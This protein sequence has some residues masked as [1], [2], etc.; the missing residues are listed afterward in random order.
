MIIR[1]AEIA[2]PGCNGFTP[3]DIEIHQGKIRRIAKNLKGAPVLD[4]GGLQLFPGAIDPHVH[5]NEPGY[6][7]RED[8]YHGS[9]A[10]ASGGVSTVIDMPCTSVPPVTNKKN[11]EAKLALIEKRSIIDFAFFG[12]VS[13][14]CFFGDWQNDMKELAPDVMGFKC[15]FLS[16]MDSF[17]PLS[18]LQFKQVLMAATA[19]G[20]PLL[21]HAEDPQLVGKYTRR[22]QERGDSWRHYYRSRPEKA[23]IRA[24]RDALKIAGNKAVNLH[25]VHVGSG[26]AAGILKNR[27]GISAET[28]P[29][30][31]TFDLRDL[32]RIGAALKTNPVVKRPFNK[33]IL[34]D[35]LFT[36]DLD[37]V[38]S[39]HA[40]A[41]AEQ[42]NSGSV[43]SDYAGIPGSGT[44]FPFLY[45][46]GLLRRKM[47]LSR[48]LQITA[49]N[50]A[51]R[52]GFFD[53]KGSIEKGKDADL[54]LVDPQSMTQVCGVDSYSKGKITPFEGQTFQGRIVKTFVRG[55]VVYDADAGILKEAGYGKFLRPAGR[56]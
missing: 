1:H 31:L 34:W 33:K 5:F 50:A 45:S 19:L 35:R 12:G 20:R 29:H 23:E 8:F 40:P 30:Y 36:G 41:P 7:E 44:L 46:E 42:K 6:T 25:I 10:A 53:R 9:C 14:R 15:Y 17:P 21:L 39:D 55:E 2:L 18:L 32:L 49:E 51:R 38:A 47:P 56:S 52:Y 26:R 48:F 37:F 13:A 11:L 28:A 43:W 27:P 22:E 54:V 16:G 24:V 3:L 4:A